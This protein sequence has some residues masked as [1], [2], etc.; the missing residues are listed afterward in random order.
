MLTPSHIHVIITPVKS[1]PRGAILTADEGPTKRSYRMR[2]RA[3]STAATRKAIIE[4][5]YEMV[6]EM[7]YEELTLRKVADRAGV[8]FQTVLR[9]FGTKD[10]LIT[11]VAETYSKKE[12]TLRIARPGDTT[13]IAATLCARYEET[14]D[15]TASWEAL[16]DRVSGIGTAIRLSREGHR[17][18][19]AGMFADAL[20]PIAAADRDQLLAQL[21]AATDI[22]TW[23]LWRRRLD[24][25]SAETQAAMVAMLDAVLA[26]AAEPPTPRSPRL[27]ARTRGK[28]KRN[29]NP[30]S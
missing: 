20:A 16:E 8:T 9:H 25:S 29:G 10:G 23:R 21:Y 6:L 1:T 26:H 28:G 14:A 22:N 19:L 4:A 12:Y 27:E 2:A 11:A 17:T 30:G 7:S 15:A 18:W 5:T 3:E 24:L 13:N